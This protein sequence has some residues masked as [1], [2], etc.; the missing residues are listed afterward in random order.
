MESFINF[1]KDK[2][3]S[4]ENLDAFVLETIRYSTVVFSSFEKI[5]MK[6]FNL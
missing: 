6:E 3:S 4:L 5:S 2:V 1:D